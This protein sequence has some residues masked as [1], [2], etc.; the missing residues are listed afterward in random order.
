MLIVLSAL[1]LHLRT[2]IFPFV[3]NSF[4]RALIQALVARSGS[5]LPLWML[6]IP[7]TLLASQDFLS[8]LATFY[9]KNKFNNVRLQM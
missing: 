7:P 8:S 2:A 5:P 1:F 3:C 6:L 9:S 4:A